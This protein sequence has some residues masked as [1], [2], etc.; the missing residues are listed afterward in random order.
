[1]KA[2]LIVATALGLLLAVVV[3]LENTDAAVEA[4]KVR[5]ELRVTSMLN[6]IVYY[7]DVAT[8]PPQCFA[9]MWLGGNNGGAGMAAVSCA[10]VPH[11]IEFTSNYE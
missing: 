2:F 4:S 10:S 5:T 6:D 11:A 8:R 7:K 9:Y 3:K 1:M